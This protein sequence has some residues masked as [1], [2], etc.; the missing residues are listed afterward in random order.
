MTNAAKHAPT[1]RV[2]VHVTYTTEETTVRVGNGPSITRPGPEPVPRTGRGLIGLDARVRLAGGTFEY[3]PHEGGFAVTARIPHRPSA[4]RPSVAPRTPAPALHPEHRRARSSV[5]RAPVTTIVLPLVVWAPLCAAHAGWDV[6]SA[7][8]SVLDPGDYARLRVG[9]PAHDGPSA[10]ASVTDR[11]TDAEAPP[12]TCTPP[13][14]PHPPG[15]SH[16]T[17]SAP[18]PRTAQASHG[19]APPRDL[20][21]RE[22]PGDT[23]PLSAC[24]MPA[25]VRA[26]STAGLGRTAGPGHDFRQGCRRTR[27]RPGSGRGYDSP[28]PTPPPRAPLRANPGTAPLPAPAHH[29]RHPPP[30]WV[31]PQ[32]WARIP[33]ILS[34]YRRRMV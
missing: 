11:Y 27:V 7:R 28:W 15:A 22:L 5:R 31:T 1:A 21:L 25:K 33:H 2:S 19:R 18:A 12:V 17:A 24:F 10:T 29:R 26:G 3:G 14:L 30:R 4:P 16:A 32:G 9:D 34:T 8:L 20:L 23:L 13:A 6:R